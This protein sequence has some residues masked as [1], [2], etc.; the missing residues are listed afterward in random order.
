MLVLFAMA[1]CGFF[2]AR[3]KWLGETGRRQLSTL[4]VH[5]FNPLLII[6][7]VGAY[8]SAEARGLVG[9][10]ILALLFVYGFLIGAALLYVFIRRYK[11][12]EASLYTLTLAFNNV[13]FMGIPVVRGFLGE[14]YLILVVFYM[15]SFNI[16]TY[17]LGIFLAGRMR[18]EG[19]RF[20]LKSL[21]NT[22]TVGAV[23]AIVIFLFNIRFPAP[24]RTFLSY[25]GEI[26]IPLSMII[27]GALLATQDLRAIFLDLRNYVFLLVKMILIP[28]LGILVI[29]RLPFERPVLTVACILISMPTAS[30]VSM[31][32]EQYGGDSRRASSMVAI[33]TVFSVVTVPLLSFFY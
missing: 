29:R 4:V 25:M 13:G 33:S 6:S 20:S 16:I 18:K 31:L 19:A 10:N 2:V 15:L 17:T 24:V 5:L 14:Q 11:R 12:G 28:L 3:K 27:I 22:G 21:L 26:T 1:M 9:Q 30:F 23:A 8:D 7:S 32:A